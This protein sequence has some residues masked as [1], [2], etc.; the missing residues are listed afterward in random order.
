MKKTIVLMAF[1]LANSAAHATLVTTE[2][3][4]AQQSSP[5]AVQVEQKV[6]GFYLGV[7][8]GTTAFDSLDY[9]VNAEENGNTIKFIAGYQFSKVFALEG[10]YTAYGDID[11][12]ESYGWAPT[13]VSLTAN[14]GYTF[15]NGLR[16]FGLIG[17]SAI[18]LGQS[19]QT[20]LDDKG[21]GLR[22]GLGLEYAPPAL[23]G[24]SARVGYEVDL[25]SVE[26]KSYD[27]TQDYTLGSFY[28]SVAYKF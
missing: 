23:K 7:G 6:K 18:D 25:F 2:D 17:I 13:A 14:L 26:F 20:N 15:S 16:S 3:S 28:A 4:A 22:Y 9:D 19:L 8:V 21:V 10:Q 24:L 5:V 1:I 12:S 11:L 27:V